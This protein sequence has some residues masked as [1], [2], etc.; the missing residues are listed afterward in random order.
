MYRIN[1]LASD[2]N[3]LYHQAALKLG[4][5]DSVMFVLYWV[6]EKDGKYPLNDIR[7]ETGISKQTLNSAMRKLEKEEII[8]LEAGSG[9]TKNVCLTEKGTELV[10]NTIARLFHAECSVFHSWT[11]QE[12]QQYL[13]LMEKYNEDFRKQIERM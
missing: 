1:R 3:A 9:R 12:I 5:S 4:L 7:K 2:L 13:N 8:Y 6:Y 11:A 10:R